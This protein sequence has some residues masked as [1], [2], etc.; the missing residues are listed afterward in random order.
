MILVLLHYFLLSK[1]ANINILLRNEMKTWYIFNA[2]LPM[3]F[4]F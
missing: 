4:D 2:H 1:F 3:L